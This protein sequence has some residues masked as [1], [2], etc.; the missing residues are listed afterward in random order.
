MATFLDF[1]LLSG[2]SAVFAFILIFALVYGLLKFSG[3]FKNTDGLNAIIAACFAI[4]SSMSSGVVEVIRV[5]TP[6]YTLLM[7]LVI[8]I[9]M[10][11]MVFGG[12]GGTAKKAKGFMDGNY[13]VVIVWIIVISIVIFIA[14][15]ASVFLGGANS[16]NSLN[17]GDAAYMSLEN[18]GSRGEFGD[19]D[20]LGSDEFLENLFNPKVLGAIMFLIL[21]GVAVLLLGYT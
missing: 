13:K 7:Y 21:A 17:S 9:L 2:A 8:I 11:T 10:I 18:N 6:W 5:V 19:T 20:N 15:V 1:S 4:I 12:F 14:G 3:F 16:A